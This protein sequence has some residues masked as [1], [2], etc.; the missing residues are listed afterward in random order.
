MFWTKL[1][2][3]EFISLTKEIEVL[4]VKIEAMKTDLELTRL[5][6][7]AKK[8]IVQEETEQ[9]DNKDPYNGV[10]LPTK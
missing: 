1:R 10:L 4:K 2:S 7:K 8:G 9:V 3:E 5:K 6:L